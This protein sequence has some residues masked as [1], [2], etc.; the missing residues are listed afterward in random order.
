VTA[1]QPGQTVL[2][3]GTG[4]VF[5]FALQFARTFNAR[6][7]AI[8]SSDEKAEKL[9][10]LSAEAVTNYNTVPDWEQKILRL[11]DGRGVDKVFEVA[12]Q[13]TIAKSAAATKVG[14]EI[15]VSG[16]ASGF[17]NGLSHITII[18]RQLTVTSSAIGPR[19]SFEAM[20]KA[21]AALEVHPEID[22]VHAF[23]DFQEAYKRLKVGR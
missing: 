22:S 8:T 16:F 21:M 17:G 13:K 18:S 15:K 5:L 23:G 6:V 20:L 11:T 14:G 4:G 19:L 10:K 9:K 12:G 2:V 1:L 7:F 3:Q